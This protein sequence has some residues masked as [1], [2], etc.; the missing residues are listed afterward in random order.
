[1]SNAHKSVEHNSNG[2][3]ELPSSLKFNFKHEESHFKE[4]EQSNQSATSSDEE[5][6]LGPNQERIYDKSNIKHKEVN[7]ITG[8]SGNVFH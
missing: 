8:S 2:F 4:I 6:R 3:D 7:Y 1:M 5:S